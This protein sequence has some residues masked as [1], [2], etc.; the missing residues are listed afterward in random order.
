MK[1]SLWSDKIKYI[2][3]Y[4]SFKKI[5][6]GKSIQFL[7][8][9]PKTRLK[10]FN[11]IDFPF[12]LNNERRKKM[13]KIFLHM[14]IT[15]FIFTFVSKYSYGQLTLASVEG[16]NYSRDITFKNAVVDN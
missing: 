6:F 4:T 8:L 10:K 1:I 15:I 13:K 9:T 7:S 3:L 16:Y 11:Y 2:I 12:L 14:F 5:I